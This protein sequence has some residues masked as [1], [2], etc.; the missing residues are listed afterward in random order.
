MTFTTAIKLLPV[1]VY[2]EYRV[3]G[4]WKYNTST[5]FAFNDWTHERMHFKSFEEFCIEKKILEQFIPE[6]EMQNYCG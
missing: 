4:K 2:K 5:G 3:I 6:Y 1:Q